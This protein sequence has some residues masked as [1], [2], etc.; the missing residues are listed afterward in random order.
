M[1]DDLER[2]DSYSHFINEGLRSY[3][4]A[5]IAIGAFSDL[6]L[7]ECASSMQKFL[8]SLSEVLGVILQPKDIGYSTEPSGANNS[9]SDW[10]QNFICL[11][12]RIDLSKKRNDLYQLATGLCWDKN[13]GPVSIWPYTCLVT[14]TLER[15]NALYKTLG[16]DEIDNT[17]SYCLTIYG[18][19]PSLKD[20]FPY[21]E[22][23]WTLSEWVS[24][25]R[26]TKAL[27]NKAAQG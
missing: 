12:S 15:A 7:K 23:E 17:E 3:L 20:G 16:N 8:P 11:Q 27:L 26:K 6:I 2:A 18:D 13:E 14:Q 22:L 1:G 4:D 9:P 19:S 25:L 21:A 24:V 10:N 5:R